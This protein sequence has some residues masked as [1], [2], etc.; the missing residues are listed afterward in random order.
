MS[1]ASREEIERQLDRLGVGGKLRGR[2]E[3]DELPNILW[4]DEVL[5][6]LV[7]GKYN[8]NGGILVATNK[9]LIFIDK[10]LLGS[11]LRVEDF[12]YDKLTSIQY[13]TGSFFSDASTL[14]PD[15]RATITIFASGNKAEIKHVHKEQVQ[16]FCDYV[17][18][19]TSGIAEHA[20][21]PQAAASGGGAPDVVSQLE[22]LARLKEQGMLTDEEFQGEK[23]KLLGS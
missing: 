9:R 2:R 1:M 10:A 21:A 8:N 18:A 3:M 23:K 7:Q 4:E 22:R 19:R 17:R 13:D 11:R 14:E 20:S 6:K 16:G 12:P 5:E 15:R